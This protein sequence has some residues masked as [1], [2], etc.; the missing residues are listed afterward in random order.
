LSLITQKRLK[1]NIHKT[2]SVA[3]VIKIRK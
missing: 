2:F 1:K 3:P